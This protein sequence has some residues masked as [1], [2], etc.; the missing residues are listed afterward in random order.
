MPFT[1]VDLEEK[2]GRIFRHRPEATRSSIG[3]LRPYTFAGI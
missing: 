3:G 1:M 2:D